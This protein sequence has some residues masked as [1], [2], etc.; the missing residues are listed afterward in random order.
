[1]SLFTMFA[2]PAMASA[3]A[4]A[5]PALTA[6][7]PS[8]SAPMVAQLPLDWLGGTWRTDALEMKCDQTKIG[9]E[10]REEG[11]SKAMKG[12]EANLTFATAS[13]STL[14]T[15]ALPMLPPSTFTEIARD[16]Q[17]VTF[18]TKTKVGVA[19]LRFT[20]TGDTLKVERG[21]DKVW[22]TTMTYARGA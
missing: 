11:R 16:G 13:A 15:V 10:C 8:A 6:A 9:I 1:M 12:A 4:A 18:E 17:S 21:N 3:P 14:L 22:A 7:A 2:V 19:R 20:R 5:P